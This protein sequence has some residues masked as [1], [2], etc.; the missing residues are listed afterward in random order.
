MIDGRWEVVHT[1]DFT[2]LVNV[3]NGK[4]LDLDPVEWE[5]VKDGTAVS[6]IYHEQ[7]TRAGVANANGAIWEGR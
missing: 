5:R 2:R 1:G 7:L 4:V 3:Y 6:R